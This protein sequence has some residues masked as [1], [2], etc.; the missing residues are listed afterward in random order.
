MTIVGFFFF[1]FCA[2]WRF[3]ISKLSVICRDIQ[4]RGITQKLKGNCLVFQQAVDYLEKLKQKPTLLGLRLRKIE[5]IL[6][7]VYIIFKKVITCVK[8]LSLKKIKIKQ[9]SK[10]FWYIWF[11]FHLPH[12]YWKYCPRSRAGKWRIC[13]A[14]REAASLPL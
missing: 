13:A 7:V 8:H 5:A 1:F 14:C 9:T 6:Y 11:Y 10:A 2:T 4:M 3:I 12:C